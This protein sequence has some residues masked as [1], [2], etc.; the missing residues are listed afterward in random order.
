M[1]QAI[2]IAGGAGTRLKARLGDLPKPL[3]P[4]AGKPLLEHQVELAR[5]YGFGDIVV[6]ACY[7]PDLIRSHLGDGTRFGVKIRYQ[8]EKTPLG[9]AGA[10]LA[11]LDALANEF[12]VFYGDTMVNVDLQRIWQKHRDAGAGATLLLHPNDHPFDS[13]LVEIDD[14][15][16]I[17]DFHNRP[18]P[19]ERLFQ[20]LVNAGLYVITRES[21]AS[22]AKDV[23]P[24]DFGKDLFP[25]MLRDGH[26]LL[27]YNTS[28]NIKDIGTPE[29][30]D[31]VS[32]EY[33]SGVVARSS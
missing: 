25:A 23:K 15:G 32:V 10:V 1:K 3:A 9:T 2:I 12:L 18:H 24:M 7:R 6:F 11:G 28:E 13:D 26:R 21:L 4:I 31:R 19:P 22:L 8:V 5:R 33:S 16:W 30:Y 27:G 17:T 20:N 14:A 29:R